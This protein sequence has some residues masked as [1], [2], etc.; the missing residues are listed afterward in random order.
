ME[1]K[2]GNFIM[3]ILRAHELRKKDLR[4]IDNLQTMIDMNLSH[5]R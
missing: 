4:E 3:F 5:G 2:R 1:S